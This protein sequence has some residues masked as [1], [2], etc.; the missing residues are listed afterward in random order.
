MNVVW[1]AVFVFLVALIFY[2]W[3]V[4]KTKIAAMQLI[5]EIETE[6]ADERK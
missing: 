6:L 2:G 5:E 1:L 4:L 3:T